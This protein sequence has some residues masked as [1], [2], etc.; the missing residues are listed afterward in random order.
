VQAREHALQALADMR[1]GN[2]PVIERKVRVQAAAAGEIKVAELAE[3]W[4]ADY[5]R[6][7]LKPRTLLDH[8]RLIAKHVKPVLGHLSVARISRDDVVSLC[9]TF[10][11]GPT[12]RSA[13]SAPS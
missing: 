11:G 4:I 13:S 12:I 8:E 10:P 2:D 1:R 9:G 6:P 3:K 5:V 7:K